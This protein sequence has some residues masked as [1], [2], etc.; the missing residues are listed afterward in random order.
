MGTVNALIDRLGLQKRVFVRAS[1]AP[2]ELVA[3]AARHDIGLALE[4]PSTRNHELC[5]SNKLFT[6]LLAGL[7]VAAT[8]T[9]GQR[10]VLARAPG[11][12]LLYSSGDVEALASR[13][14]EWTDDAVA[15]GR[16]RTAAR[17]AA[18]TTYAW[19]QERDTLVR[20]LEA[21]VFGHAELSCT[22]S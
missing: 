10:E 8:N 1:A 12:G 7:A 13:L 18:E 17:Y 11:A 4:Q 3:R 6:Y 21:A 20:H 22:A 16:A 2:H 14:R 5:A 9:T 19:A 15:L